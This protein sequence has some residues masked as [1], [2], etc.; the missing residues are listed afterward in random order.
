MHV[1]CTS[2]VNPRSTTAT[3]STMNKGKKGEREKNNRGGGRSLE[4]GGR[5]PTYY[6]CT[7]ALRMRNL[8]PRNKRGGATIV[9]ICAR[10]L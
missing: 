5:V 8:P 6:V 1:T 2:F 4:L 7:R 9:V 10:V 3:G